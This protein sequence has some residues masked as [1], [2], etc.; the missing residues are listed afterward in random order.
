MTG[1][2]VHRQAALG[3]AA[4]S[5]RPLAPL[6]GAGQGWRVTSRTAALAAYSVLLGG[7]VPLP[8]EVVPFRDQRKGNKVLLVKMTKINTNI[9][10]QKR[11]SEGLFP[12]SLLPPNTVLRVLQRRSCPTPVDSLTVRGVSSR[13]GFPCPQP[14]VRSLVCKP[15]PKQPPNPWSPRCPPS[16]K[17][18]PRATSCR[19]P[20]RSQAAHPLHW[21]RRGGRSSP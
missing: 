4:Q 17:A 13:I 20:W 12:K 1:Q 8:K 19:W 21:P 11:K 10:W 6:R 3:G 15:V 2:S 7:R 16:G 5:E 18:V 9:S 14:R